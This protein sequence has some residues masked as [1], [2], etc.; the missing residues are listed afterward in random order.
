MIIDHR[1][2]DITKVPAYWINEAKNKFRIFY[3]HTSHGKQIVRGL[4]CLHNQQPYDF[5]ACYGSC[6]GNGNFLADNQG[7]D[8]GHNG[9]L[10]WVAIT[11]NELNKSNNDRN[12]VI[13]SWC[14]GVSDN[15]KEGI[16]AYLEAMNK[17]E[18]DY[19][20]VIL[21]I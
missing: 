4:C 7:Y 17:L 10:D 6:N 13:W 18:E 2:T 8:L 20:N 11:R 12:V 14:G 5:T 19:P 21:S 3:S 15:T 9:N 16:D 1:H